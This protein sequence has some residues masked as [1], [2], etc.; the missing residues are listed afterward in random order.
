MHGQVSRH[1]VILIPDMLDL[2]ALKSDVRIPICLKEIACPQMNV[3]LLILRID[4]RCINFGL[5]PRIGRILLI[6]VELASHY[7]KA[8]SDSG[9]HQVANRKPDM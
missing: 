8:P 5:D 2:R 9:N 1:L 6:D 4:A 7:V 3:T